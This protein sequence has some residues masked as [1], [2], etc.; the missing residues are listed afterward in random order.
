VGAAVGT[1]RIGSVIG[2]LYAGFVLAGRFGAHAVLASI[3]ALVA[4]AA[5]LVQFLLF[6]P[7]RRTTDVSV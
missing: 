4:I 2:P 3:V 6:D 5:V 1:G 7:R